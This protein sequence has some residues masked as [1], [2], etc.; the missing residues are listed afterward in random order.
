[1]SK[2]FAVFVGLTTKLD[3]NKVIAGIV[4]ALV[5]YIVSTLFKLL[6]GPRRLFCKPV[7]IVLGFVHRLA[8]AGD[9]RF[10]ILISD[11]NFDP[12][13]SS[14]RAVSWAFMHHKAI[15]RYRTCQIVELGAAL[16]GVAKARRNGRRLL[17]RHNAD[18]LVAGDVTPDSKVRLWFIS[19]WTDDDPVSSSIVI[20][21]HAN[22][23][24]VI[25]ATNV[26][27][28]AA[29]LAAIKPLSDSSGALV[30]KTIQPLVS[31]LQTF[32]D[33][34][35][36]LTDAQIGELEDSLGL[37]LATIAHYTESSIDLADAI[38]HY[39][40]AI[41]LIDKEASPEQ[42]VTINRHLG[43]A[44]VLLANITLDASKYDQA[45]PYLKE[46]VLKADDPFERARA[47]HSLAQLRSDRADSSGDVEK[48]IEAAN[49]FSAALVAED[50]DS[51]PSV[52]ADGRNGLA[53]ALY[54][55]GLEKK[56]R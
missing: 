19:K 39:K 40:R 24:L 27:L 38:N 20:S 32:L 48:Q 52:W 35:H 11:L 23:D 49:E 10:V 2:L 47:R 15:E 46:A 50:R 12:T 53:V 56:R 7:D 37:A 16:S 36:A 22:A 41:I 26:R 21:S 9:Q 51:Y 18:L 25:Q 5:I 43:N 6:P 33:G 29:A 44:L 55:I 4:S 8:A 30:V 28:L 13:G 14:A 1:M 54:R 3:I 34:S 17:D 45:E 42:W 31:R